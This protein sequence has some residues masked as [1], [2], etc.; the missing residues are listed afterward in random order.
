MCLV[1]SVYCLIGHHVL[2][3]RVVNLD[4]PMVLLKKSVTKL[5]TDEWAMS[6]SE[7]SS[8]SDDTSESKSR[9][10]YLIEAVIKQKLLFN[11]RPRPIVYI[12]NAKKN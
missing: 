9:T 6:E 10:D 7:N 4:K 1:S 3:G 2:Y 5:A 8:M 12:D 11:K